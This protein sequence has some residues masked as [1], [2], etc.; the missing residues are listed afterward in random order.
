MKKFILS[1]IA[2]V[3]LFT[4]SACAADEKDKKPEAPFGFREAELIGTVQE[5][6]VV[7]VEKNLQYWKVKVNDGRVAPSYVFTDEKGKVGD[8]VI[9]YIVARV[10]GHT[11]WTKVRPLTQ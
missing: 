4:V 1:V 10:G 5:I 3:A 9:I 6:T 2:L 11:S 7:N 8:R